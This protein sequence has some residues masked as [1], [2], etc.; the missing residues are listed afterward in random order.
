MWAFV[1]VNRNWIVSV[2]GGGFSEHEI[3]TLGRHYGV[4]DDSQ[5]DLSVLFSMAQEKLKKN[6]FEY[7]E[8][9]MSVFLYNDREK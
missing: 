5:T 3:I 9:L 4:R 7:F 2:T 6:A 8:H 1:F